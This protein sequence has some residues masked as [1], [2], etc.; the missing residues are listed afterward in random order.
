MLVE[1]FCSRVGAHAAIPEASVICTEFLA[2]KYDMQICND[3][4]FTDQIFSF[5]EIT[6]SQKFQNVSHPVLIPSICWFGMM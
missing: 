1:L 4:A 2:R 6:V 5:G 3:V